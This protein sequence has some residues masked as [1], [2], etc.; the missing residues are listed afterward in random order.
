MIAKFFSKTMPIHFVIITIVLFFAFSITVFQA[1][2]INVDLVQILKQG[3]LFVVCFFSLFIFDFLTGKNN[4]TKKNSYHLLL[5]CL[6]IIL[7]PQSFLEPKILIANLFIL[8]ALRRVISLRS[9]KEQKKK[10]FDAAFWVTLATLLCFWASLFYI[11]IFAALFI[12]KISDVKNW[13]IPFLGIL[14]VFVIGFSFVLL[15]NYPLMHIEYYIPKVSFD[16]STLNSKY[17]IVASTIFFTYFLWSLIFYL[18]ILKSKSKNYKVSYILILVAALISLAIIIISPN[19]SGSEFLFLI[20]PLS[21]I[22]A[23]YIELIKEKWFKEVLIWILIIAP[24]VTL[25]L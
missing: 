5:Y 4:L 3:S 10:I 22:V 12:L 13:I 23:N 14:T 16:F 7:I 18:K 6:F 11:I 25:L 20:A 15:T 24:I 9:K 21:I 8:F 17:V 2:D 19:K 1:T